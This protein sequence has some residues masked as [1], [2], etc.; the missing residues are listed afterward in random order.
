MRVPLGLDLQFC[1]ECGSRRVVKN[2]SRHG[3]QQYRCRGSDCGFQ[4]VKRNRP[5]YCRFP[6]EVMAKSIELH[7]KG[8]SYPEVAYRVKQEYAIT[9][10]DISRATVFRWMERFVPVAVDVAVGLSARTSGIWSVEWVPLPNV[11]AGCWA[12]MDLGS[13]YVV[14]AQVREG[15]DVSTSREVVRK[16]RA[17]TS[18]GGY[19][20]TVRTGGGAAQGQSSCVS[21]FIEALKEEFPLDAYVPPDQAPGRPAPLFGTV[22]YFNHVVHKLQNRKAF[23]NTASKQRFLDACAISHNLFAR[24]DDLGGSTPAELA[25]VASPFA[26]WLDVVTHEDALRERERRARSGAWELDSEL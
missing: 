22:G 14:A 8:L 23:R 11:Q 16:A 6:G 21:E 17:A 24:P 12:V 13:H 15:L 25:E 18:S 4:F 10:A 1:P 3:Q 20:F 2:G 9:D 5:K 7:V 26:S 19:Q